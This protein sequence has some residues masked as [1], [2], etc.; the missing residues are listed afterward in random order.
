MAKNEALIEKFIEKIAKA[1]DGATYVPATST[2][3]ERV[4]FPAGGGGNFLAGLGGG[5]FGLP[6]GTLTGAAKEEASKE[7]QCVPI[8]ECTNCPPHPKIKMDC[9]QGCTEDAADCEAVADTCFDQMF[10]AALRKGY[11]PATNRYLRT[12][13]TDAAREA[14]K[15]TPECA[16]VHGFHSQCEQH[17]HAPGCTAG[18]Q[19]IDS[20]NTLDPAADTLLGALESGDEECASEVEEL[21][22]LVAAF[23][24]LPEQSL[25]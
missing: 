25:E 14:Y 23:Q 2:Q 21:V 4:R 9:G 22:D 11:N 8:A 6:A 16:K 15:A 13:A 3:P 1:L 12:Q 24:D 5:L 20:S 17:T 7:I 18:A 10:K 19:S